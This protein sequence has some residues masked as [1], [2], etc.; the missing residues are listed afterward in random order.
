MAVTRDVDFHAI[1]DLKALVDWVAAQVPH[2][3]FNIFSTWMDQVIALREQA[4]DLPQLQ[5]TGDQGFYQWTPDPRIYRT[6]FMTLTFHDGEPDGKYVEASWAF[7]MED[8]C[9]KI[10]KIESLSKEQLAGAQALPENNEQH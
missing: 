2:E 7:C 3:T 1:Q 4:G 10:L 5:M 9:S 6:N 8:D